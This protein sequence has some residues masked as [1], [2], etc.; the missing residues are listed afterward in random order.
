MKDLSQCAVLRDELQRWLDLGHAPLTLWE[1]EKVLSTFTRL[2]KSQSV[3]YLYRTAAQQDNGIS[4]NNDLTFCGVYDRQN[5]ALYLTADTLNCIAGGQ[6]PFVSET[7]PSM[8][9]ELCGRINQCV[10]E[11]IADNRENL[12]IREI[13]DWQM[14]RNLQYYQEY[15]A[16]EEAVRRFFKHEELDTQFHSGYILKGL[17]EAA[18]LA[19][20]Q[21]PESFI[22]AEAERHIE[23]NQEKFLLQFLKN[24][25]LLAAYQALKQN[26]ENPIHRMK[27][28]TDAIKLSGA[29]TVHVTVSKEGKEL[30]FKA[31]ADNLT[32][33]R[34]Y[35]NTSAIPARDRQEFERLFGLH[36]D[37]RPEEITK[38]T[39][40]R[41]TIYRVWRGAWVSLRPE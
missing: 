15:G 40:G 27:S 30:T 8:A 37:Y 25:A 33:H 21:E 17:P 29:K 20:L 6:F 7:I 11:R 28:I 35:Y 22:Q 10:E 19:W 3:E 31:P 5:R 24:D 2:E 32:G 26:T 9:E 4:W 13:T 34:N 41:S 38:I 14:R 39:Y 18:F 12:H 1:G 36:A 23:R 16:A